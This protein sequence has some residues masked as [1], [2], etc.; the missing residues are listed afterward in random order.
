M[1]KRAEFRILAGVDG[2][3]HAR[4][5]L[6]TV[7][8]GPWPDGARVR[9]IVARQTRGPH[10]RSILLSALDARADD[11]ADRAKL[12]LAH[13]WP[14]AEAIV[15][16]MPPVEG[17]LSE[18]K[19]FSADVIVVGWRGYGSARGLL[20]GSV[21]R[22]VVRG[23]KGA[24]L[25]VRR[26]PHERIRR[27]VLAF[28]ASPN[29]GRAVDLVARLSAGHNG[30]VTLVQAVQL[31][32]PTSR[33]PAV[34]G[35]RTSIDQELKRINAERSRTAERALQ[36]AAQELNRNGWRTDIQLRTGEPLRELIQTVNKSRAGLLVVGARGTSG[37]RR[38][39]L[40]SV[41]EGV[42]SRSP[43]PVLVAR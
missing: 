8:Q 32:V 38:L 28:D 1:A 40:G 37:V 35:I 11:A 33:G 36:R 4:A 26:R 14:D 29:A 23:A 27:I 12:A 25:V 42:L 7:I 9:A 16:D 43:V 22:G 6:A 3:A 41:A 19:K 34:R 5:A 31:V 15:V 24:V 39:L 30:H 13:R 17:I 18:A 10:Q 2:S 20:M 21:S